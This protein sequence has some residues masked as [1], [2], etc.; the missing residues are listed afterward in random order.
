MSKNRVIWLVLAL[1]LGAALT[2]Y[3]FSVWRGI[4]CGVQ[5]LVAQV[6]MYAAGVWALWAVVDEIIKGYEK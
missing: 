4:G 1:T 2:A 5:S 6:G 3:V